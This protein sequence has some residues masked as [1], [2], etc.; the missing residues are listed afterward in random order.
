MVGGV[1]YSTGGTRRAVVA[2][3][4]ATGEMLWMYSL[5]EGKRGEVG[6][7]PAVRSRSRVLDRRPRGANRLR[8]TRLPDGGAR[9][10]DGPSGSA[11]RQERH[12]RSQAGR[13]PGDGS[14]HR[15]NRS[16]RRSGDRRRRGRSSA[17]RICRAA[18]RAAATTT[19]ATSADST[20]GPASACGSST[21][22]RWRVRRASRP[23]K[24]HRR[25]IP[26]TPECGPR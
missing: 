6:A 17:Q 13:R 21:R 26:A 19:T 5:N 11:V 24:G 3:D 18:S 9:R 1:L 25:P 15:R 8:H 7:A 23:G 20:C 10:Q 12:R 4:A 14:R 22:F 16:A 2:L